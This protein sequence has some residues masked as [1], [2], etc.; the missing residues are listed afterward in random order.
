MYG[1]TTSNPNYSSYLGLMNCLGPAGAVVG[2]ALAALILG[3]TSPSKFF[4]ICD[5]IGIIACCIMCIPFYSSLLIGRI[6]YG[7]VVG[8][9]SAIIPFINRSYTPNIIAGVVGALFS[10]W[11]NSGSLICNLISYGFSSNWYYY[12]TIVLMFPAIT[13]LI[14]LI[15]VIGHYRYETPIYYLNKK[16]PNLCMREIRRIYKPEHVDLLFRQVQL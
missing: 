5:V 1:I 10:I 16:Q 3:R 11:L 8:L 15:S 6:L 12:Y 4:I 13:C 7:F 14:R 2:A 9:N